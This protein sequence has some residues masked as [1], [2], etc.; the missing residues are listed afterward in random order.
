MVCAQKSAFCLSCVERRCHTTLL[1]PLVIRLISP[2]YNHCF[3]MS[4]YKFQQLPWQNIKCCNSL[5]HVLVS[6]NGIKHSV[7]RELPWSVIVTWHRLDIQHWWSCLRHGHVGHMT[8]RSRVVLPEISTSLKQWWWRPS[9][10]CSR[11]DAM[12]GRQCLCAVS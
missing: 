12:S 7:M 3:P 4:Y 8:E 11:S 1:E 10:Q 5:C 6:W 2:C 9:V